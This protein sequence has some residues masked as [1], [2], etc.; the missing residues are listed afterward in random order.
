MSADGAWIIYASGNPAA[1]GIWKTRPDGSDVTHLLKGSFQ[2]PDLSPKS[3]W[4][5]ATESGVATAGVRPV[6]VVRLEDGSTV[7]EISVPG[8]GGNIGRSRW[9]PDGKTLVTWGD[10]DAHERVLFRQPIVPGRDTRSERVQIAVGDDE[11][12]IESFAISPVD[13]HI[14]V[15]AARGDRDLMMAE[16]IPGVG[17][18]LKSRAP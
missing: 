15:S 14:V 12:K 5:A 13:G 16:G 18:S 4:I 6:R 3:N 1:P 2:I 11:R 9:M 7:G 17:A 10:N 8:L